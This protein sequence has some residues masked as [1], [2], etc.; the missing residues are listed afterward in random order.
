MVKV[1]IIGFGGIVHS[2]H[3]KAH[4]NLVA[5]GA[6]K[7]VAVCDVCPEK[8]EEKFVENPIFLFRNE[9]NNIISM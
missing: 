8:F 6:T 3:L 4:M 2:T 9:L 1:A 5:K 7:L